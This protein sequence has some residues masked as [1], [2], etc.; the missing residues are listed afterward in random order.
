MLPQRVKSAIQQLD[1]L[2]PTLDAAANAAPI[3]MQ[4]VYSTFLIIRASG[5]AENSMAAIL[6]EYSLVRG[7]SQLSKF[8]DKSVSWENSLNCKK[9]ANILDRFDTDWWK[10]I[11]QNTSDAQRSAVD[12]LKALRDQVA[13]GRSNGTGFNII[14]QYYQ[15]LRTFIE[16]VGNVVLP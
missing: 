15:E 9:I 10:T 16:V 4:P 2:I 14:R 7:N 13:H 11:E 8:V 5:I 1:S 6:G 3:S 12:S